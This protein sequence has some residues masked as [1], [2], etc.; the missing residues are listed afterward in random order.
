M[1]CAAVSGLSEK[2]PGFIEPGQLRR[3]KYRM[4]PATAEFRAVTQS[5]NLVVFVALRYRALARETCLSPFR[6][7]EETT[8]DWMA[9]NNRHLFLTQFLRLKGQD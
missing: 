9:P 6:L 8:T 7:L 1:Q 4:T 2:E 5:K 3:N